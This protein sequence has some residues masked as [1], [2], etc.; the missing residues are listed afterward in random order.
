MSEDK[1]KKRDI[2]HAQIQGG[3]MSETTRKYYNT[4]YTILY[5][6]MCTKSVPKLSTI[7]TLFNIKHDKT[8]K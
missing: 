3:H 7:Y 5:T 4:L 8:R 2:R 1:K 6:K